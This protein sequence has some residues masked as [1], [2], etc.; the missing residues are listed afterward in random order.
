MAK[1]A[2]ALKINLNEIDM[3]RVFQGKKGQYLDATIFVNMDELDQY[4]NSGMI[5]QDVSKEEKASGTK[6]AILGNGK[7]FWVENGQAPQQ[8]GEQQSQGDGFQQQG[9]QGGFQQQPQQQAPQ[10]GFNQQPQQQ[11]QQ[12]APRDSQGFTA[13]QGGFNQNQQQSNNPNDPP[14]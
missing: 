5:T 7:V 8:P 12:Q 10:A 2:L 6:G 11:Q 1:I 9:P 14:F 4:G 13:A 3:A